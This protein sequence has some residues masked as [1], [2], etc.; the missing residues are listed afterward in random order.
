MADKG[1]SISGT[2]LEVLKALW[3]EGPGTVRELNDRLGARGRQWAYTTVQTLLNRLCAKGVVT[4]DKRDV[5][6]V[7]RPT[8]SRD[9]LLADRLN[10]LAGELC[11]G[12]S[13]PLV[14]ALVQGKRFSKSELKQ[15]RDLI[16][17]LEKG[18]GK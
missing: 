11:E 15:F 4:S 13:A 1:P 9:D 8:V 6:H 7:Y 16:D 18:K 2:E 14:L 10:D 12:A 5:A 17:E 3:D